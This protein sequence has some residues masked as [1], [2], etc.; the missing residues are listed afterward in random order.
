MYRVRG[1]EKKRS[2]GWEY[3]WEYLDLDEH[4]AL[5]KDRSYL[6]VMLAEDEN[7]NRGDFYAVVPVHQPG[8]IFK[9]IL[10]AL[11][12]ARW[13]KA[14]AGS[15]TTSGACAGTT[16]GRRT[17]S[18]R[19]RWTPRSPGRPGNT[20]PHEAY[21]GV[22]VWG[23]KS[24]DGAEPVRVEKALPALV[25]KSK[26]RQV[27]RLLRSRAPKVVHSRRA[28]SPYLL[29][30]L[31]KC[32]RCRKALTAA[33]AKGGKYTYYV[34]HSLLKKGSGTCTTPPGS[35]PRGSRAS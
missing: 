7:G 24:R 10:S 32:Q 33:E 8:N 2:D 22:L 14:F 6:L 30:G 11:S 23:T 29:S 20:R 5:D 28:S 25:S 13:T 34:C 3:Y 21:T 15:P 31:V 1:G 26:Y 17:A 4:P 12:P 16:P 18:T 19:L 9:K 27:R 35:T